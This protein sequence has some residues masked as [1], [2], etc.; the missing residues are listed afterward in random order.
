MKLN[1]ESPKVKITSPNFLRVSTAALLTIMAAGSG[2]LHAQPIIANFTDGNGTASVDQYQGIAG[3]GWVGGWT[4]AVGGSGGTTG[5]PSIVPTVIN[6]TPMNGGGNYLSSV[7]TTPSGDRTQWN[8]AVSRQYT[9][10]GNVDTSLDHTITF[11]L[12]LDS[13]NGFAAGGDVFGAFGG[14]TASNNFVGTSTWAVRAMGAAIGSS[15]PSM[16]WAAYNGGQD[17]GLFNSGNLV[18]VGTGLSLVQGTVYTFTI[19]VQPSTLSYDVSVTNG[20]N[21]VSQTGLGFRSSSAP[22]NPFVSFGSQFSTTSGVLT[23]TL[24]F[25]ADS[26]TVVPEPSTVALLMGGLVGLIALRRRRK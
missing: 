17:G 23:D 8:A 13:T 19:D 6:T 25:S 1:P 24:T 22:A 5:S 10:F 7:V 9:S 14:S 20:V 4:T 26:V 11:S 16:T 18:Q 15:V 2:V 21:T 3:S 12:R